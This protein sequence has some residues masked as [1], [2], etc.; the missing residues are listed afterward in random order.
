MKNRI[1]R[2]IAG[3]FILI[4]LILAI[5]VNNNWLW[6]TAFVGANLLQSSLT[7]WCLMDDILTKVFKVKD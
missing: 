6:F 1:V 7:K 2:G 3:T 4:S 5:K